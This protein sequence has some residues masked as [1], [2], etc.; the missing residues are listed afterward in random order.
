LALGDV[1]PPKL[2]AKLQELFYA[3]IYV[4]VTN[5]K[6]EFVIKRKPYANDE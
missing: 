4:I 1:S 2:Y 5:I 6:I 3:K